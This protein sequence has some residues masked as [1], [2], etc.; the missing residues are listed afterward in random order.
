MTEPKEPD[1][2]TVAEVAHD[3]SVSEKH[4]RRLIKI[5]KLPSYRFG[6]AVRVRRRDKEAY[7]KSCLQKAKLDPKIL[8]TAP[9]TDI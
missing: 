9:N 2:Q 6:H 8:Y 4:I 1:F 5:G 3:L 7:Q